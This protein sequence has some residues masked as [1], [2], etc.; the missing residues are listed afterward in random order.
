M[1][2]RRLGAAAPSAA[3][4]LEYLIGPVRWFDALTPPWGFHSQK[5]AQSVQHLLRGVGYRTEPSHQASPAVTVHEDGDMGWH[6]LP[7]FGWWVEID[8][9]LAGS[10]W[11]S[12]SNLVTARSSCLVAVM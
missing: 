9:E 11:P 1:M 5:L 6:A 3:H 7:S 4:P 10:I 12:R 2:T 8:P